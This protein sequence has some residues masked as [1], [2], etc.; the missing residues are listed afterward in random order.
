[1]GGAL[2]SLG[3]A[4]S[5]LTVVRG[6]RQLALPPPPAQRTSESVSRAGERVGGG[7]RGRWV[8]GRG[9]AGWVRDHHGLGIIIHEGP[10]PPPPPHSWLTCSCANSAG[11][12]CCTSATVTSRAPM[13]FIISSSDERRDRMSTC[14]GGRP[15][16]ACHSDQSGVRNGVAAEGAGRKQAQLGGST[17]GGGHGPPCVSPL[18][19]WT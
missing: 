16:R 2:L 6:L 5:L 7:V 13:S 9:G 17:G 19:R 14:V 4:T 12:G 1:M 10:P 3:G 11:V 8:H 15:R 18:R